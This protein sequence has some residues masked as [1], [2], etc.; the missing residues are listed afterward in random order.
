MKTFMQDSF[1]HEQ[2]KR[3]Y[4][5]PTIE[6]LHVGYEHESHE[7]SMDEAGDPELNY[8]RWVTQKLTAPHLQ[9]ILQY[10]VLRGMRVPYLTK[11]Q[12]RD[13][14]W[15]V[16]TPDSGNRHIKEGT[17]FFQKGNYFLIASFWRELPFLDFILRDPSKDLDKVSDAERFRFYCDC[18][19]INTLRTIENLL[20][21]K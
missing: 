21:I 15:Q 13:N 11:E 8:D 19:D 1:G 10:N 6:E 14:G 18:K 5:T 4:F 3:K 9:T 7:W 17:F 2:V 12:I 16:I 20:N